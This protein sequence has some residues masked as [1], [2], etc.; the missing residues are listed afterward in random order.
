MT[1]RSVVAVILLTF[2]T[3]GIYGLVWFVKTKGEMVQAGAD[4][5][6]S[7]LLIVPIAS[8]WWMWKWSGGVEHVTRGKQSQ[9]IAFIL[10]FILGI[11]GMAIVQVALNQAIDEG[12][13]GNLARARVA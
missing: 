2:I 11:I 13:P 10:V 9:V 3:F 4:I 7:W 8:I 1:K 6:T 12:A 5:P